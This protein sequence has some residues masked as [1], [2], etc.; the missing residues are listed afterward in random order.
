[1]SLKVFTVK[2]FGDGRWQARVRFPVERLLS[3][4]QLSQRL[5]GAA[6]GI[7]RAYEYWQ[8]RK[9][10]AR[11]RADDYELEASDDVSTS[12]IDVT[13]ESPLQY[14]F[15]STQFKIVRWMADRRLAE[16]PHSDIVHACSTEYLSC[17]AAAEPVG[18]HI[19]HDLNGFRR[20]YLRLLLPLT[21]RMGRVSALVCVSRHLDLPARDGSSPSIPGG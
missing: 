8:Q 12:L 16:F 10:G 2:Q 21:D 19:S 9:R 4:E 3:I 18:H 20:D 15:T 6:T 7:Q 13:P 11:V 1:M 5:G 17:K 14:R